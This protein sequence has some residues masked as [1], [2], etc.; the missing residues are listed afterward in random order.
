MYYIYIYHIYFIIRNTEKSLNFPFKADQVL[1]GGPLEQ[2]KGDLG[3]SL[4][5][6]V[7]RYGKPAGCSSLP[8]AEGSFY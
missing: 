2:H 5:Q 8:A 3:D 4:L 1:F 6:A 7:S